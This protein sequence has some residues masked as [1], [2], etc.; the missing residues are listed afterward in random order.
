M[1][2]QHSTERQSANP[3]RRKRSK[4]QNFK[5]AY[6]PFALIVAVLV[7]GIVIAIAVSGKKD[8][9]PTVPTTNA[10]NA[11]LEQEATML[12]LNAKSLAERYDYEGALELLSGFSGDVKDFPA[13]EFAISRYS[14][15][16]NSMV[17]WSAK[18]VPNLSFHP[19]IADLQAALK[20]KT[21]GQKGNDLY[22]RN[23]IT[24]EEF[25]AILNQLYQNGYV[26]VDLDDLYSIHHDTATNQYL[27]KEKPLP[28]PKGKK[29]LLLTQTHC[30]Y[31]GYMIDGNDDGQPDKGGAGFASKLKFDVSFFNEMVTSDGSTVTGKLDFVPI[32]EAFISSHPD[33]SYRGA[34]AILAF[35]G[36]D[37]IFGYRTQS[38]NLPADALAKERQEAKIL[39]DALKNAG[40][41]FACYSYGNINY[42]LY[43][44]DDIQKDLE[45]WKE[46]VA[47]IIGTTDLMVFA[48]EGD[49]GTDYQN[50][51][52]FD[53]LYN[54]GYRYYLGSSS[55]LFNQVSDNYV[56]HN[57]LLVTGSTLKHN[58]DRFDGILQPS[59]ILDESRG[60]IPK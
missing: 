37:G 26:L 50:N 7:I 60:N 29:P 35:S 36:Y 8:P 41:T 43:N 47:S 27:Y 33:F 12:L 55:F 32:L 2:N 20:D 10:P 45:D 52:K 46:E 51:S 16:V 5:E 44:T 3:R 34:R 49:I 31:Y 59:D 42:Q 58:A 4:I 19:L 48:R 23:F 13:I 24:T 6:L 9:K 14:A 21:Y 57:R 11:A 18:D 30:T 39:A 38:G 15:I 40:Y 25:S 28:L 22:N 53:V 56:R 1:D 17:T 54:A